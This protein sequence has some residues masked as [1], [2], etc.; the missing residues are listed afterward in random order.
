MSLA[1]SGM[2]G[3][4]TGLAVEQA[5]QHQAV[6][7]AEAV[8]KSKASDEELRAVFQEFVGKTFYGQLLKSMRKSVG[9][10]AYFHGGRGEEIF[11]SQLDQIVV[12]RMSE[13]SAAGPISEAMFNLAALQRRP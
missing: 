8:G 4:H 9:K 13:A 3:N 11:R 6:A 5:A 2:L 1:I 7:D 12:E 10:P